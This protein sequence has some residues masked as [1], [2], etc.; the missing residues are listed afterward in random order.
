MGNEVKNDLYREVLDLNAET[1]KIRF[2]SFSKLKGLT[3][4]EFGGLVDEELDIDHRSEIFLYG[5]DITIRIQMFYNKENAGK[6]LA[7]LFNN[8]STDERVIDF[9]N[10]V[11]NLSA[12]RMKE[13]FFD[14]GI[15]TALSLPIDIKTN[16][17]KI[18]NTQEVL[19][20]NFSWVFFDGDE[21]IFGT[22]IS[23]EIHNEAKFE[24]FSKDAGETVDDGEVE[25]F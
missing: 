23:L 24:N 2:E 4:T 14:Q 10:E 17:R 25:F 19:P 5:V 16:L 12:G 9:F 20:C 3:F 21:K 6:T 22:R 11:C 18:S 8:E 13:V 7:N 15:V 1:V